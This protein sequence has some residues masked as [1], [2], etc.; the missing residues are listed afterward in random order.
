MKKDYTST[1][2]FYRGLEGQLMQDERIIWRGQP[3]RSAF[4]LNSSI[5]I[6]PF[7]IIWLLVDSSFI[8]PLLSA[9]AMVGKILWFL[10]PFFAIHLIPVWIWLYKMMNAYR[11]WKN[12]EYAISD[13]R[14]LLT[15]GLVGN[16]FYSIYYKDIESVSMQAGKV[17]RLCGVGVLI[18]T[19]NF[20]VDGETAGSAFLL[21]L[22]RPEE[23]YGI[24]Q[25]TA[26]MCR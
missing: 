13:K 25:K 5:Q 16:E 14:I 7:A 24:L 11:R 1:V 8:I 20:Q 12:T 21:D 17:D 19:L 10:I 22:E 4:I 26:W 23:V 9:G 6:A 18:V 3:K 2:S 15:N